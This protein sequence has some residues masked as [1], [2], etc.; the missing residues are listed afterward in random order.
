MDR[1]PATRR[2]RR[3]TRRS[4]S[5]LRSGRH[6]S[7]RLALSR[8]LRRLPFGRRR[9]GFMPG[10]NPRTMGPGLSLRFFLG[11]GLLRSLGFSRRETTAKAKSDSDRDAEV[12]LVRPA[13]AVQVAGEDIIDRSKLNSDMTR[14]PI[15]D[16]AARRERHRR[17]GHGSRGDGKNIRPVLTH[18][19]VHKACQFAR[20]ISKVETW[21]KPPREIVAFQ[22]QNLTAIV[23]PVVAEIPLK[24]EA[25]EQAY[26]GGKLQAIEVQLLGG[27]FR[28]RRHV[29]V[30]VRVAAEYIDRRNILSGS[31]AQKKED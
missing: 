31:N 14:E 13:E 27:R 23:K 6:R 5:R 16:A 19:A 1:H 3:H 24:G 29:K 17:I 22:I 12:A 28:A 26:R 15:I 7:R 10:P 30:H 2:R 4:P 11:L 18:Q 25:M 8:R 21:S 9:L 20:T